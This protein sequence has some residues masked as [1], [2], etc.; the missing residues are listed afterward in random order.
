LSNF[1]GR[2]AKDR[3]DPGISSLSRKE[4][5]R[6]DGDKAG[7]VF[8]TV[9]GIIVLKIVII[10]NILRAE[11]IGFMKS[12]AIFLLVGMAVLAAQNS[13]AGSAVAWDGHG[14]LVSSVGYSVNIAKERALE[15]A[16][17]RYGNNV[18]LLAS[19]DVVGYGAIAVA[20]NGT[21]SGSIIG[22]TL[23]RASALEAENR[24]IE[25]CVKAGGTNP[26]IVRTFRG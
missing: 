19:S 13:R 23:G 18:R 1:G 4:H 15:I 16:H 8:S 2:V 6:A 25:K 3:D 17:R 20:R 14:H 10:K 9:Q 5:Q 11:D 24:S 12:S 22:V 7:I 21:G 26:K